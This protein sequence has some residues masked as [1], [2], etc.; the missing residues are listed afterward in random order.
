M[1]K[2]HFRNFAEKGNS[3][4]DFTRGNRNGLRKIGPEM[5]DI[6]GNKDPSKWR[7]FSH[8]KHYINLILN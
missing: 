5:A 2:W 7:A 3:L 6:S 8:I 1:V 4:S